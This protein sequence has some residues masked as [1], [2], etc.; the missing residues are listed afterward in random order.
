MVPKLPPLHMVH[1][2]LSFRIL[3]IGNISGFFFGTFVIIEVAVLRAGFHN[4]AVRNLHEINIPS[5]VF[6]G[7]V[8]IV[9]VP[10]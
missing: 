7:F 2:F 4:C 9:C 10:F 1:N 3:W 5:R 8:M 6:Q